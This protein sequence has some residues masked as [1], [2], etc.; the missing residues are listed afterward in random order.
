MARG[1][2]L[3]EEQLEAWKKKRMVEITYEANRP[4]S[5]KD[6]STGVGVARPVSRAL[7][8]YRNVP[9]TWEGMRFDSKRELKR[10]QELR[11]M[12]S[13]GKIRGLSRQVRF[14]IEVDGQHIC[15][16]IADFQY[17]VRRGGT[18]GLVVED[19]KGVKTAVYR[20]KK[21]LMRAVYSIEITE[22]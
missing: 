22:S 15:D 2:R 20:L 14:K 17:V 18:R 10:W 11:L 13:A 5:P 16:Y 4:L 9:V 19:C 8:K 7:S 6:T 21:K 3:T 12:Y 1:L